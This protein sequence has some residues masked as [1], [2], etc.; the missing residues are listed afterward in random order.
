MSKE[1]IVCAWSGGKDSAM[2]L[3]HIFADLLPRS[4][5][6]FSNKSNKAPTHINKS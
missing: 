2:A 1:P 5:A 6:A 3:Q 4:D